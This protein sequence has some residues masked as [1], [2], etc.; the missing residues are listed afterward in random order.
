M[1]ALTD[2]ETW[3]WNGHSF[4]DSALGFQ[5][6]NFAHELNDYEISC[7]AFVVLIVHS[8]GYLR[9]GFRRDVDAKSEVEPL[10]YDISYFHLPF[11][12]AHSFGY[13]CVCFHRHNSADDNF[14]GIGQ[15]I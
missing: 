12:Y 2:F 5:C 10:T 3:L 7:L 13:Q 11:L 6:G 14:E 9:F 4:G 8:C 15:R 1:P